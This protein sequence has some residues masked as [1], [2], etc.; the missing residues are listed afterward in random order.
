MNQPSPGDPGQPE[1]EGTSLPP[2]PHLDT[3]AYQYWERHPLDA[4]EAARLRYGPVFTLHRPG[5]PSRILVGDPEAIKE[6]FVAH[7]ADLEARG[8]SLFGPLVGDHSLGNMNGAPHRWYRKLLAPGIHGRLLRERAP[9]IQD[10]TIEAITEGLRHGPVSLREVTPDISLRVMILY[11][12][13]ELPDDRV[14]TLLAAFNTVIDILRPASAD[15]ITEPL[16]ID[17]DLFRTRCAQ[18]DAVIEAEIALARTDSAPDRQQSLLGL[19]MAAQDDAARP[20]PDRAIRD[21]LVTMMLAGQ[22]ST[23]AA[24]VQSVYWANRYPEIRERLLSELRDIG[25]SPRV[26][27]IAALPYLDAVCTEVLRL[28]SVVPTGITRRVVRGFRALGHEF[29]PGTEVVPCIH[30]VHRCAQRYPAP[31]EFEPGRFR[32]RTYTSSEYLPYGVGVRRCLGAALATL[33]T[34]LVVASIMTFPG[35][36]IRLSGDGRSPGQRT[37]PTVTAQDS[38]HLFTSTTSGGVESSGNTKK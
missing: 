1:R 20:V 6:V 12:F 22:E 31:E 17:H 24:I 30:A 16:G 9:R 10:I 18:L 28:I 27:D 29:P 34:K 2:G 4:I 11:C 19:M 7:E 37:G 25:P 36:E 23:P 14:T 26:D 13:G 32:D 15:H 38:V 3:S 35:L 8:S 21:Q 5:K 33:E